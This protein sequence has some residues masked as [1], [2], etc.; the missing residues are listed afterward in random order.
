MNVNKYNNEFV[1]N[2]LNET[3]ILLQLAE[4]AGELAQAAAKKA[5]IILG[6]NPTPVTSQQADLDLIGEFADV[7]VCYSTLFSNC[8]DEQ[9]MLEAK[10]KLDRWV[11]RLGGTPQ[12]TS[13]SESKQYYT[14][15]NVAIELGETYFGESD[16]TLWTVIR[17]VPHNKPHTVQARNIEHDVKELKPSWLVYNVG[18]IRK[19]RN[20]KKLS[21][22]CHDVETSIPVPA[23]VLNQDKSEGESLPL[24]YRQD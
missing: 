8:K 5:R 14:K 9:V 16:G 20:A 2:N 10:R 6:N 4:E 22:L 23:Y 17:F 21:C 1:R 11:T 3:D 7:L 24:V 15:D 19:V 12:G 13:N 18:N